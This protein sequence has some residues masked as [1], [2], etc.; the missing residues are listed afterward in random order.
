MLVTLSNNYR[1][2]LKEVTYT[3]LGE[4]NMCLCIPI[5]LVVFR[6]PGQVA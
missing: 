1:R 5:L 2:E 3:F 4:I 6:D